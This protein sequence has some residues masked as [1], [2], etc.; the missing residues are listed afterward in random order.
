MSNQLLKNSKLASIRVRE[1]FLAGLLSSLPIL[2][3]LESFV[4]IPEADLPLLGALAFGDL[5][6]DFDLE[7][8]EGTVR[9]LLHETTS[10][11]ALTDDELG[12]ALDVNAGDDGA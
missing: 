3:V 1:G 11:L 4:K 12:V 2:I 8:H 10:G 6:L 7:P 9:L 5:D